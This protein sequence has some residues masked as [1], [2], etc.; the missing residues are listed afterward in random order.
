MTTRWFFAL[1]NACTRSQNRERIL[2]VAKKAFAKSGAN[3]SL[4][5]IAKQAAKYIRAFDLDV[6]DLTGWTGR[7]EIVHHPHRNTGKRYT[8]RADDA[9]AAV[10]VEWVGGQ[11]ARLAHA[12]PLQ[13]RVPGAS[14]KLVKCFIR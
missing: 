11:D 1:P 3:A 14:P 2:V 13:N 9:L 7:T 4:D 10:A 8:H 5:D 12:V 6:T